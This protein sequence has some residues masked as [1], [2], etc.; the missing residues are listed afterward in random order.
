MEAMGTPATRT[1]RGLSASERRSSRRTRLIEAGLDVLGSR[2]L[3]NMTMT[4]VCARAGLTERYFYESFRN[5]DEMLVAI[6]DAFSVPTHQAIGTALKQAPPD[7][8]ERCRAAVG[9]LIDSLTDDPR[10]ARAY[11]EA[12]SSTPLRE[13]R[14]ATMRAYAD[15]LAEQMRLL[16]GLEADHQQTPLRLVT[17]MLVGGLAEAVSEW[18]HGMLPLSKEELA[19]DAARLCVAAAEALS[20][21]KTRTSSS[22]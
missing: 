9:A 12:I 20:T 22:S 16:S 21:S 15:L 13:R 8:F 10:K 19:D 7:L 5:L 1:Y 2:G 3:S 17:T 14:E 4:S 18:L 6:F 11:V